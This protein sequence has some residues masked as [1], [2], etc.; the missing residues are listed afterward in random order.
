MRYEDVTGYWL[1][2]REK[3]PRRRIIHTHMDRV[4]CTEALLPG[5]DALA[6]GVG[7]GGTVVGEQRRADGFGDADARVHRIPMRRL[8]HST[9]PALTPI[10]ATRC[11]D[12]NGDRRR[13]APYFF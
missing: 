13:D 6:V 9:Q 11:Y 10:K 3:V 8:S 7:A 12:E 4:R 2:R 5:N 1:A